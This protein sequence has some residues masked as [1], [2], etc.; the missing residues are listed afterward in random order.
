[1][2]GEVT[3]FS[4]PMNSFHQFG[5]SDKVG[6]HVGCGELEKRSTFSRHH[7]F[8]LIYGLDEPF[9]SLTGIDG[10]RIGFC[11]LSLLAQVAKLMQRR[12]FGYIFKVVE[13][14]HSEEF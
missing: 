3:D 2:G 6:E 4:N 13:V 7:P 9:K 5:V 10:S 14:K 11:I 12:E 8:H 1:M